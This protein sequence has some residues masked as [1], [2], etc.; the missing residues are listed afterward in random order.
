M[1]ADWRQP[2]EWLPHAACWLA[3][4]SHPDEWPGELEGA[5]RGVAEMATALAPDE[6]V[7]LLVLPGESE[8]SAR[9]ALSGVAVRYHHI[10]FGDVWLRDTGPVFTVNRAGQLGAAC[11]RWTGW[12]G[13]YVFPH[14]DLVGPRI[15]G[16]VAAVVGRFDIACEGGALEVDGEGTVLTTRQCLLH[17]ERNPG[18]DE[19]A[20]ERVLAEAVG[21]RAVLWLDRGLENDHT[22]GHI[23][24]LARFTQPGRVVVM[25]PSGP[26]DPNR[27][28]LMDIARALRTMRD[29][30]G[31][32]LEVVELPSPSRIENRA[33]EL[34]A[35]S[36][37]NFYI[38]NRT[39]IAPVY[40]APADPEA[41][42]VL[43][44]LFP[45]RT[46]AGIDARAVVSGGGAF[47]CISQQQ[48]EGAVAAA[49]AAS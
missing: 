32:P 46:I 25:A 2:A 44:G 9:A 20:I 28:V 41:L 17:P 49:V 21:A 47:H 12:A 4:P 40:G 30:A 27:Q 18:L 45:D 43:A 39:V 33:G 3:W 15:A 36:Y 8:E 38:G 34:L 16:E 24:T 11:F 35:A 31:R 37:L 22:D 1:T 29:A 6:R 13:K 7:E 26:A 42:A 23:D 10:P 14:D 48:P 19:A 5:R